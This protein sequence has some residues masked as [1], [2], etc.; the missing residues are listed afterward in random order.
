MPNTIN[1][2]PIMM[3]G[4]DSVNFGDLSYFIYC[5]RDDVNVGK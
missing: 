5:L 1:V 3:A 4:W 2:Q